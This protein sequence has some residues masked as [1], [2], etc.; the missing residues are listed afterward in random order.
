[1]T[2]RAKTAADGEINVAL[3]KRL[4]KTRRRK[5]LTQ[6]ELG[7]AIGV[8]FNQVSL[9]ERGAHGISCARFIAIARALAVAPSE[10]LRDFE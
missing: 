7:G 9:W 6:T 4:A 2:R 8:G 1:M 3:G 5:G 10:L